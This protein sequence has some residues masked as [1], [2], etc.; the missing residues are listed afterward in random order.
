MRHV[1]TAGWEGVISGKSFTG[2]LF[3]VVIDHRAGE[4]ALKADRSGNSDS[5]LERPAGSGFD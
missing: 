1:K 4:D 2:L 5:A 3:R